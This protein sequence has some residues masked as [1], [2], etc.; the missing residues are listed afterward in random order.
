LH[1]MQSSLEFDDEVSTKVN[2]LRMI[3]FLSNYTKD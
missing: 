1:I 3:K 2:K